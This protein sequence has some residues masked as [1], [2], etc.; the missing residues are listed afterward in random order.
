MATTRESITGSGDADLFVSMKV[1]GSVDP[2]TYS[3]LEPF[4]DDS[5]EDTS[6]TS[7][8]WAGTFPGELGPVLGG[9][10]GVDGPSPST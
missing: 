6:S 10:T 4:D 8:E 7:A 2:V 5:H 3:L 1:A 9:G